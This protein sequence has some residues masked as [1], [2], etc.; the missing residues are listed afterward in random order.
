MRVLDVVRSV[1][2][3]IVV[4][5]HLPLAQSIVDHL[6][7]GSI[8]KAQVLGL[9]GVGIFFVHTSLVLM[10]SLR[11]QAVHGQTLRAL[12]LGFYVRRVFRIYPLA[13]VV[14]AI[15][16][17]FRLFPVMDRMTTSD[18]VANFFLIQNMT[19]SPSVPPVL[20]SLPFE[21]QMYVALPFVFRWVFKMQRGTVGR[22]ICLLI[23]SY[24]TVLGLA[25]AGYDYQ[26]VKYLPAFLPGV[27]AVAAMRSPVKFNP[28]F[29]FVMIGAWAILFPLLVGMGVKEN[30]LI[31]PVCLMVGAG[32][33]FA[34]DIQAGTLSRI[35]QTIAKYSFG[36]YLVHPIFVEWCF[37][38]NTLPVGLA[39]PVFLLGTWS[40]SMLLYH[41]IEAPFIKWGALLADR[42]GGKMSNARGESA[43]A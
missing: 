18:V 21:V 40:A 7:L 20:W 39:W 38:K 32:L 29:L 19:D 12:V 37:E 4:W 6:G 42:V 14:V 11:R 26:L 33:A 10:M 24:G 36:I 8:Y 34:R 1:A 30:L 35:T 22:T 28:V 27:L 16:V 5:S 9:L 15:C 2:V 31:W 43:A 23:A 41:L 25:A 13:V 17:G 3:G